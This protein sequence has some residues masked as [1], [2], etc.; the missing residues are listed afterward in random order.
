[1]CFQFSHKSQDPNLLS[2]LKKFTSECHFS[3][4]YFPLTEH[5]SQPRFLCIRS[6]YQVSNSAATIISACK[7]AVAKKHLCE[8]KVSFA[9]GLERHEGFNNRWCLIPWKEKIKLCLQ[10]NFL[11]VLQLLPFMIHQHTEKPRKAIFSKKT[12]KKKKDVLHSV[13]QVWTYKESYQLSFPDERDTESNQPTRSHA[14]KLD[15]DIY[16][17]VSPLW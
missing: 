9:P 15:L 5:Q 14:Q 1:M 8:F 7:S 11:S 4:Y 16:K 12:K 13:L 2:T 17:H 10:K 6:E 3:S